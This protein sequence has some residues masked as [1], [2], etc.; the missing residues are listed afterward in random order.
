MPTAKKMA[1]ET[2]SD[3]KSQNTELSNEN[4]QTTDQINPEESPLT[5]VTNQLPQSVSP[6]ENKLSQPLN[7]DQT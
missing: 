7:K 6:E 4:F 3:R 2:P 5:S 1:A